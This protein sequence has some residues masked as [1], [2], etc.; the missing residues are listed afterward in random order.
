MLA[1]NHPNGRVTPSDQDKVLTRAIVLAAETIGVK[2]VDHLIVSPNEMRDLLAGTGWELARTFEGSA[3][4][5]SAIIE[6]G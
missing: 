2:I 4:V 5:Y 6:K 3:G 1:H